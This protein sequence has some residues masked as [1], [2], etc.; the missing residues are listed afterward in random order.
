[1][2][3]STIYSQASFGRLSGNGA[4]A[5][6][7]T[8]LL[9]VILSLVG[10]VPSSAANAPA[11]LETGSS[12]GDSAGESIA[13][14]EL[15]GI[16]AERWEG[17]Q[18]ALAAMA[19][20]PDAADAQ[21][22][23]AVGDSLLVRF[24]DVGQGDAALITCGGQN[25]LIDGGPSGAS[26]MIYSVLERLGVTHLDYIVA[27]HPDADHCGGIAGALN[28]ADCGR[29]Y[30]SVSYHDTK[31]FASIVKYLGNT[32][33][34]I[35]R[36]DD[37]FM[38]GGAE[39]RFVGP[40]TPTRDTNNGS[41]VC[42]LTYGDTRFLFTGDAEVESEEAMLAAGADLGAD[43]LKVGHHG[44]DSSSG[45]DFIEC[46]S[47]RYAIVSV[48]KNS[49]GHPADE[50]MQRLRRVGASVLRTDELGTI[51][52]ESNGIDLA[53]SHTKGLVER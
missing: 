23:P 14:E 38:V 48:G 15:P 22:T 9:V 18:D 3:R 2:H 10:C 5:V 39:V 17:D 12:A 25:L 1:M 41:L 52:F 50:V 20:D 24:L 30:C 21:S 11:L 34:T 36:Y 35:P 26:S 33:I 7:I 47:P 6:W 49:Y 40:V 19:S 51:T 27:T 43:V 31:T 4:R 42:L 45:D 29:F 8:V 37:R 13:A 46:V 16:P 44:S 28:Y 32:P 53:V